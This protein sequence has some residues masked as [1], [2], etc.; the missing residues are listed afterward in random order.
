LPSSGSL[1]GAAEASSVTYLAPLR[2]APLV[3]AS[4]ERPEGLRK[5][6]HD[7]PAHD[8]NNNLMDDLDTYI[9]ERDQRE[10]GFAALVDEKLRHRRA[11]RAHAEAP[12]AAA[13]E[14]ETEEQPASSIP[15][16]KP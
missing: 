14:D 7:M 11:A 16:I 5:K 6:A 12:E 1:T 8:E 13:R 15:N 10:P 4:P 3:I 2:L 9:S